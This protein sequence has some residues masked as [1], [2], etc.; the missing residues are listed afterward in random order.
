MK[1]I[2][3]IAFWTVFTIFA[4]FGFAV[5][6]TAAIE[7]AAVAQTSLQ[8][9]SGDEKSITLPDP[10]TPEAINALVS[11]LSESEVRSLLLMQLD[12]VAQKQ[13]SAENTVSVIK[14]AKTAATSIVDSVVDA[15]KVSPLLWQYQKQSFTNFHAKL[16]W[17]GI[18]TVFGFLA[19]AMTAGFIVEQV[20]NYFM[21]RRFSTLLTIERPDTLRDTLGF[22]FARLAIELLG[23]IAFFIVTRNTATTL[24]PAEHIGFAETL[25]FNLV[26]LPRIGLALFRLILAPERPE[27]RLLNLNTPQSRQML[28]HMV[29]MFVVMG[30]TVAIVAFGDN[31]GVPMGQSRLGFWLNLA[32]TGFMIYITWKLW[33]QMIAIAH[34]VDSALSPMEE[35]AARFYPVYCVI[36]IVLT[37]LLTE[38]LVGFKQFDLLASSPNYKTI[39]VLTSLPVFDVFIRRLV[40]YLTPPMTGKGAVAERAHSLTK[41]AYIRIGRI[42]VMA[43]LI[44]IVAGFWNLNPR[45]IAEAGVGA[46]VAG[47]LIEILIILAMGYL[48]WEVVS[49]WANRKLAAEQ[50]ALGVDP[51]QQDQGGEGGGA[52]G[53][54]LS[55]VV[56]LIL[57]LAKYGIA[58]VFGLVIL[59]NIG[60]DITPLLA[61]A[62]VLGLAIGFGAQAM[63]KDIVSGILF[64]WDDAFRTG[65]YI[66]IAGTVGTVERI[67]L[68]SLQLRHPN[69][70]V[71]VVPYGEIPKLTNHSRDYVIMKLRF[72]VPFD[73]DLEKVRKLFKKIGQEMM[74]VPALAEGFIQP[75]KSQGAADVDDVG[76]VVRGK[77][78]TKPGAQ[79]VIRKEVYSRVQKAFEENGIDF[80]RREV[81]VQIPGLDQNQSISDDQAKVIG[82]AAANADPSQKPV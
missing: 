70:P 37:W 54:R 82:T 33:D 2:H 16:G 46:K 29:A 26:V 80:A 75:F 10:L 13:Q 64:L 41:K 56:P 68:R 76:I 49:L 42:L 11:R 48:L 38:V 39:V 18:G 34:G 3:S 22:L 43:T 28:N 12:A 24:I 60:I 61:G 23:L 65:E 72:T 53:S 51:S 27:F 15:V 7:T 32:V 47:R 17:R 36:V 57:G 45:T 58:A 44:F 50:T 35:K 21:R 40:R 63:V 81:R 71:H 25:M 73:T 8:S 19:L 79:W 9:T 6:E 30:L 20:V 77:F 62:G 1:S 59:S 55:T 69:G 31:N 78:T 5:I 4:A 52:G 74:Q 67:S 14:F 66:D